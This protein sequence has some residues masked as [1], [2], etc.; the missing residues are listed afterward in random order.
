MDSALAFGSGD[1]GSNPEK[2]GNRS[3]SWKISKSA[4]W[5]ISL[6]HISDTSIGLFSRPIEFGRGHTTST[7]L[8]VKKRGVV[9]RWYKGMTRFFEVNGDKHKK[10]V[11]YLSVT[12]TFL[13]LIL[14]KQSQNSFT[15]GSKSQ[16]I[17][18]LVFNNIL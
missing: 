5:M 2:T 18:D 6:L 3:K 10:L 16:K 15:N 1:P 14:S 9:S 13:K 8:L 11:F 17:R 7:C 4:P 12:E